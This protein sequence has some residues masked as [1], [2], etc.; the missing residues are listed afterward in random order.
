MLGR[1]SRLTSAAPMA[2][3]SRAPRQSVYI[4]RVGVGIPRH[5]HWL[6]FKRSFCGSG[7]T[8]TPLHLYTMGL[9]ISDAAFGMFSA[10]G[11]ETESTSP[12]ELG[13]GDHERPVRV[14]R[15][16]AE[17]EIVGGAAS[18][19]EGG[20]G[21]PISASA[22]PRTTWTEVLESP[23]PSSY[24]EVVS[25]PLT[26]ARNMP[27]AASEIVGPSCSIQNSIAGMYPRSEASLLM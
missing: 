21:T 23:T 6:A 27:N 19:R 20:R 2:P 26:V 1:V 24:G 3:L 4:S 8:F 7:Y 25:V 22:R 9:T 5:W 11:G 14:V 12:Y 13:V 18:R 15:G 17:G 10:T 16:V